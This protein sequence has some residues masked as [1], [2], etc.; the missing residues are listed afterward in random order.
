MMSVILR[1]VSP[2]VVIQTAVRTRQGQWISGSEQE[3]ERVEDV[4]KLPPSSQ[5]RFLLHA[6]LFLYAVENFRSNNGRGSADGP[7]E[8]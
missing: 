8:H 5:H 7:R 4:G 3:K 1:D 2:R 6:T